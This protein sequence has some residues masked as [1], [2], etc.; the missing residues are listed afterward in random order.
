MVMQSV[1]LFCILVTQAVLGTFIA[2][3]PY[4]PAHKTHRDF[5]R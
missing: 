3:L 4:F 2:E 1:S 5:F